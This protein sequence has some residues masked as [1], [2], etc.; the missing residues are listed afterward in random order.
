MKNTY[1]LCL[2]VLFTVILSKT[3][4]ANT[5]PVISG[6][7]CQTPSTQNFTTEAC[8]GNRLC[9]TICTSDLDSKDSVS[10]VGNPTISGA[11]FTVV[12]KGNR[13]ESLQFCWTPTDA[14]A[15]TTPYTFVVTAKDNSGASNNSVQQTFSIVVKE[16]PKASYDT[17]T[18]GCG[19]VRFT[20]QKTGNVNISQYLWNLSS[21]LIPRIGKA[22]DTVYHRYKYPGDKS[23][24]LTLVGA[25]GCNT[26]YTD[27]YKALDYVTI[28][29]S[30]DTTVCAGTTIQL[31]ARVTKAK[32]LF[33]VFWS[34]GHRFSK[35]GGQPMFIA[36]N[37]DTF[38]IARVEDKYCYHSD[39]TFIKVNE[40]AKFDL[41]HGIQIKPD[42]VHVFK[43]KIQIDPWDADTVFTYNWYKNDLS[44][45]IS[46]DSFLVA[47]ESARYFLEIRD[48]SDCTSIDSVELVVDS[49]SSIGNVEDHPSFR[50]FPNPAQDQIILQFEGPKQF[51]KIFDT[52][53]RLVISQAIL[54]RESIDLSTL[55]RGTYIVQLSSSSSL[56]RQVLIKS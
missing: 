33:E 11:S 48:S 52:N 54:N 2:A 44:T 8:A 39:T 1:T 43:P 5:P 25:N 37:N 42:S 16:T 19:N 18:T 20:A 21:T 50:V 40:P 22:T 4:A 15:R 7:N 3:G 38:V 51:L 34:T 35:K 10:L 26:V 23:Y 17:L 41:G 13:L 31:S 56:Q 47:K 55:E 49:L 24:S 46:T 53:G 32:G 14:Q 36:A 29:T 9:F 45:S 27:T 6:V 30:N 28:K 12:N